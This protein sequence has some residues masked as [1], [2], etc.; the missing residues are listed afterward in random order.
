MVLASA[1]DPEWEKL[2]ERAQSLANRQSYDEAE[3]ALRAA[4]QYAGSMTNSE[5]PRAVVLSATGRLLAARGRIPEAEHCYRESVQIL[6]RH[7]PQHPRLVTTLNDLAYVVWLQGR[8]DEAVRWTEKALSFIETDPMQDASELRVVQRN[9]ALLHLNRGEKE[10]AAKYLNRALLSFD[11][12]GG[13]PDEGVGLLSTLASLQVAAGKLALAE[14]TLNKAM[15]L[16][17]DSGPVVHADLLNNLGVVQARLGRFDKASTTLDRA[18]AAATA[19]FG[20]HHASNVSI[21]VNRARDLPPPL[22]TRQALSLL[23]MRIEK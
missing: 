20:S 19:A 7:K 4:G 1:S 14:Q 5:M 11:A 18:E 2:L 10:A 8:T 15:L 6:E 23:Q 17:R 13:P 22:A 9:L 12:Q 16:G 21:L 3:Q